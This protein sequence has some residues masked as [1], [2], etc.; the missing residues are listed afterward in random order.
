M[1][2]VTKTAARTRIRTIPIVE[3]FGP[4]IQGEGAMIGVQTHFVRTG[5]CDYRCSWFDTPY[6]VLPEEVRANSIS[7]TSAAI[8]AQLRDWRACAP[9]ACLVECVP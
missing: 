7:M 1:T 9:L 6:A 2:M 4:V 3:I 5:G 8:V